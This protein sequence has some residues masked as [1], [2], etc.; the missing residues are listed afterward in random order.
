MAFNFY[1]PVFFVLYQLNIIRNL[2]FHYSLSNS[3]ANIRY[4]FKWKVS[5][6]FLYFHRCCT[7]LSPFNELQFNSSN[8][9]SWQQRPWRFHEINWK[10]SM[11]QCQRVA[12]TVFQ[13]FESDQPQEHSLP[14]SR[15]KGGILVMHHTFILTSKQASY[16]DIMTHPIYYSAGLF[17]VLLI[18]YSPAPTVVVHI[19]RYLC[20]CIFL[21]SRNNTQY[22]Y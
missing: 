13:Q 21:H 18:S 22:V 16:P 6:S 7:L 4:A 17:A 1:K 8:L 20:I 12:A 15:C 9:I 2:Q 14:Q 5:K 11:P 19:T 10:C 3:E